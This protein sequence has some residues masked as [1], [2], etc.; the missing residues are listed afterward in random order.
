[1]NKQGL[2]NQYG[3]AIGTAMTFLIVASCTDFWSGSNQRR[4]LDVCNESAM[5]WAGTQDKA[6]A[7]CNCVLQKMMKKYPNEEDAFSHMG[8]LSQD[9]SLI[10][11]KEDIMN[12]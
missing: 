3:I 12:K 4:F 2:R 10:N 6:D 8:E 11:C 7:Y 9:T 1:M 5:K